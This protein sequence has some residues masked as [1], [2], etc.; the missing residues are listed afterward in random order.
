M[1]PGVFIHTMTDAVIIWSD[2]DDPS[3]RER[4]GLPVVETSGGTGEPDE[5]SVEENASPSVAALRRCVVSLN[6]YM[7]GIR[8]IFLITDSQDPRLEPTSGSGE[9]RDIP[10]RLV[11]HRELF[12]GYETLLPTSSLFAI[13]TMLWNISGLSDRFLLV[14]PDVEIKRPMSADDLFTKDGGI[15]LRAPRRNVRLTALLNGFRSRKGK[16]GDELALSSRLNAA[17]IVGCRWFRDFKRGVLPL[18][19]PYVKEFFANRPELMEENISYRKSDP[20]QFCPVELC[21]LLADS[22]GLFEDGG[23]SD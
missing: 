16:R 20:Y 23:Q 13:E 11:D 7:S 18:L 17:E 12:R 8:Y 14:D 15:K 4:H 9:V 5:K 2:T 10:V 3:Y 19:K 21:Y 22:A 1:S 6:K